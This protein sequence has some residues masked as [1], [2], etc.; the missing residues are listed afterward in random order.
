MPEPIIHQRFNPAQDDL[1]YY[2][3]DTLT[4]LLH[5]F[6]ADYPHLATLESIGKSLEGR[7]LWLV[8]LTNQATGPASE[9][10]AY[11]IDGNTHAGEVTGSTVVLY[12]LWR[13][14]SQYG[15][16][17]HITRVLDRSAIYLMPRISVDGAE[18]YLTTPYSLRSSTRPYPYVEER[19]GLYPE[20]IDGNGLILQMCSPNP[21]GAWVKSTKDPRVMRRREIDDEGGEYYSLLTEG[22]IR[23]YDGGI[24]SDCSASGRAG[25]Q[26]QLS[27]RVGT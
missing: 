21:N 5:E 1:S 8:T 17:A 15:Q 25:Y 18:R 23:N 24:H 26:P 9:K 27:L 6:V 2:S 11:W 16:D 10:P 22:L 3:Y 12:T 7:E 19:D 14:V 4:R 13:Y 20:D